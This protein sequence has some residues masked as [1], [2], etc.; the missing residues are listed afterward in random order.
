MCLFKKKYKIIYADP[1]WLYK[2]KCKS[3][4]GAERHYS[5]MTIDELCKMKVPADDDSVCFMWVTYPQLSEGLRLMKAW[6]FTY[7]T[8]AFTWVKT[9]K[10]GTIYL[11]MGNYTRANAE[12]YLLGTRGKT[13]KRLNHGIYNTQLHRRQRHSE[14]PDKFRDDIVK[15]FGDLPRIELFARKKTEGWDVWG[16][17]I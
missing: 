8:V 11:G 16:D 1:P 3:K 6:G 9:N 12:I 5:C 7:K 4:G 13:L 10:N 14:K 15:L 2:N 17:E